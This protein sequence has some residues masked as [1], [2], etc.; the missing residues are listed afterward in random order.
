MTD[1]VPESDIPLKGLPIAVSA[2]VIGAFLTG[3]KHREYI[4][5]DDLVNRF[6]FFDRY[7]GIPERCWGINLVH[8]VRSSLIVISGV[9][10]QP[11]SERAD[12]REP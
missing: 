12:W 2:I 6:R 8:L 3:G 4:H 1:V 10:I 9:A 5:P 11:P 7:W